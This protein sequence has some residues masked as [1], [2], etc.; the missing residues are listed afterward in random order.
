M[1]RIEK[2]LAKRNEPFSLLG[3]ENFSNKEV[4]LAHIYVIALI[5]ACCF[6]EFLNNL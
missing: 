6:A 5:S 2:W 1:K 3:G 4:V